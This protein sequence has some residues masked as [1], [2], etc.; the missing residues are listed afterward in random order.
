[1]ATVRKEIRGGRERCAGVSLN[2]NLGHDQYLELA[3]RAAA[4][5]MDPE[6]KG[7]AKD[8]LKVLQEQV[9]TMLKVLED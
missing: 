3:D 2:I 1:V 6:M 9:A 5:G 7:A 4:A 8:Q